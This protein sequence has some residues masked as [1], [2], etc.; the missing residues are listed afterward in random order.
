[1]KKHKNILIIIICLFILVE[2]L[3]FRENIFETIAFSLNIWIKNLVPSLF[4]F[5]IIS[6]I[7][8]EYN[9]IFYIPK[10]I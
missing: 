10:K 7:L 9:I 4:P 6:D 5:F 8:I 2:L 3:I 1:M